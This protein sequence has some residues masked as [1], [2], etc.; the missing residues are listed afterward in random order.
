MST[1]R[2]GVN[3]EFVRFVRSFYNPVIFI[4][5]YYDFYF[6]FAFFVFFLFCYN[7]ITLNCDS[8]VIFIWS[9]VTNENHSSKRNSFELNDPV[10]L[11][12][13]QH[14]KRT[15]QPGF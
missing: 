14:R 10:N 9:D 6:Y 5:C 8:P 15:R 12:C 2:L 3:I 1:D 13:K 7:Y 11:S 4:L